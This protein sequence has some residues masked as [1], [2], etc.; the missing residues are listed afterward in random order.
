MP[1]TAYSLSASKR[2]TNTYKSDRTP[3]HSI[4]SIC[5]Q[6]IH[7]YIQIRSYPSS[8]QLSG[9]GGSLLCF[10]GTLYCGPRTLHDPDPDTTSTNLPS[11]PSSLPSGTF[12]LTGPATSQAIAS[13]GLHCSGS[14]L[15]N[16]LRPSEWCAFT[17]TYL[18]KCP[19]HSAYSSTCPPHHSLPLHPVCI[20]FIIEDVCL[21]SV[22]LISR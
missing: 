13:Q 4:F 6:E 22:A 20:S 15:A 3:P 12:T 2:F 14:S 5:L 9:G 7:K 1:S 8:F 16:S 21:L 11:C 17:H 10:I 18:G 19:G